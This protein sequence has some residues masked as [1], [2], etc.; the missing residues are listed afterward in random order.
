VASFVDRSEAEH[1]AVG[2][3]VDHSAPVFLDV[4]TEPED[5]VGAYERQVALSDRRR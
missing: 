4:T 5:V 3:H 1:R 2:V